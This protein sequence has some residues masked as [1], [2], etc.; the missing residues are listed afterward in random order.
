LS[1]YYRRMR[2]LCRNAK[3]IIAVSRNFLEYGLS[4]AGRA[5]SG[6]D[7]VIPIGYTNE[8]ADAVKLSQAREWWRNLGIRSDAFVCCFFGTIGK[9]FQLETVIEAA[10]ILAKEFL[11]QLVL[12]GEGSSLKRYQRAAASAD[13]ICFPG[14]GDAPRIAAWM[15][16]S[17]GGRA[18]YAAGTKMALPNKP[19]EYFSGSLPVV[20]SIQGEL[21][22]ILAEHACGETYEADSV[23]QLCAILRKLHAEPERCIKMG[24]NG[25]RLLKEQFSIDVI[26][27]RLE[28]HLKD[29]VTAHA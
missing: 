13:F 22:T 15:E 11:L 21:K 24:V 3:G 10:R 19:F 29:L 7:A 14:R 16:M 27:S 17:P 6:T 26:A 9:F 12:C 20:S 23:E 8:G 2:F 18:P 5:M 4:F 1:P 28:Q 25:E